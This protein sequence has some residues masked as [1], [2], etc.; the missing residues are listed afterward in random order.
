MHFLFRFVI[1]ILLYYNAD[2]PIHVELHVDLDLGYENLHPVFKKKIITKKMPIK[3]LNV[4]SHFNCFMEQLV[5]TPNN[6]TV[7]KMF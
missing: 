1:W 2:V 7:R 6:N 4:F 5:A 3:T